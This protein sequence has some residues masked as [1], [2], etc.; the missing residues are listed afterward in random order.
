MAIGISREY[1][2]DKP[3]WNVNMITEMT[4]EDMEKDIARAGASET[5][6]AIATGTDA[7]HEAEEAEKEGK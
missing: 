4:Q 2:S 6:K 3:S 1:D 7:I 5:L